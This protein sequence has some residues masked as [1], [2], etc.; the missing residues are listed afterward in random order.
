MT[1]RQWAFKPNDLNSAAG[2]SRCGAKATS[3]RA[4]QRR[5]AR[6]DQTD[7]G[8]PSSVV[9]PCSEMNRIGENLFR[10][11]QDK[12]AFPLRLSLPASPSYE[13]GESGLRGKEDMLT[14]R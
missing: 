5:R 8:A 14:I 1:P 7:V 2:D 3:R 11:P 13:G 10:Q 6:F 9:G 4:R 12:D